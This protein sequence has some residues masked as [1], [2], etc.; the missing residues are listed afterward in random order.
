MTDGPA[1]RSDPSRRGLLVA[2]LG[3]AGAYAG[4]RLG[5]PAL[6]ERLR[7][8]DF[9]PLDRPAGF[10]RLTVTGS[11]SGGT[12]FDPFIG[13]DVTAERADP[14]CA[15]LFDDTSG[16]DRGIVPIAYFSDFNCAYCR[17]LSPRLAALKGAQVTWHELP[18]LGESSTV[19]ARAA[20]AAGLQDAHVAFH[21]AL[22]RTPRPSPNAIAR[23]AADLG[24]DAAHLW[25]DMNGAA[26]ER[27]LERTRAAAA[28]FGF[29]AT[30]SMVVGRT[31]V[32][33]A[34]GDV[35][36]DRLLARERA[37]EPVPAC[38]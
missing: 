6:S 22:M 34:L 8:L 5:L 4:L 24:L 3:L 38:V 7:E 13:L 29:Y 31:A 19:M 16:P 2:G 12:A 18:L 23:I 10:R 25:A 35:T 30:P 36:L 20:L 27:K 33:G 14:S 1:P 26:V 9:E 32:V 17:V 21:E 11:V 37:D 28:T 15:G